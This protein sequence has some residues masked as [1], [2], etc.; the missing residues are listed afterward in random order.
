MGKRADPNQQAVVSVHLSGQIGKFV[1]FA[2][3]K[4]KFSTAQEVVE[5]ML[6]AYV[7]EY[8]PDRPLHRSQQINAEIDQRRERVKT[9]YQPFQIQEPE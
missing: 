4:G 5:A 8:F 7:L 2:M 6:S 9:S 1:D 3:S